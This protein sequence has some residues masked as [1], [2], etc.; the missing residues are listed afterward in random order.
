MKVI[1]T[2]AAGYVGAH[3]VE[4]LLREG[5]EVHGIDDFSTGYAKFVN[6]DIR[7]SELDICN[8]D[9]LV[10]LSKTMSPAGYVGIV[11]AAGVKFA[12][13]SSKRPGDF[14][15]TNSLGT[16]NILEFARHLE[17]EN[18]VF[19]SS[20]SVYGTTTVLIPVDE[21]S[22]LNPVSPY[23][24]SKL[25]AEKMIEDFS[26]A[27]GIST[28]SLRYFNVAGNSAITSFDSS[29]HNLFPNLYKSICKS[30]PFSIYGSNYSTPD[31]TCI[32]DYVDVRT[33]SDAH[34]K[35]L[36]EMIGGKKLPKALNLGSGTGFSVLEI[37]ETAR[38][39]LDGGLKH[40]FSEARIGDPA[41]ILADIT[42]ARK[43][44][45]WE[46]TSTLKEILTSGYEAWLRGQRN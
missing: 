4:S 11:H 26:V 16:L 19:S 3:V 31:G 39:F 37:V 25:Y 2:G 13:E 40:N 20:C 28:L 5:F 36:E 15:R 8:T 10:D 30:E 24:R 42:L 35:S 21:N 12:G 46:H 7:F 18:F 32:R 9:S 22:V 29:P 34:A 27:H 43:H 6:P 17:I 41:A 44:I 45:E 38:K 1:V 23:G 14:Y 33:L